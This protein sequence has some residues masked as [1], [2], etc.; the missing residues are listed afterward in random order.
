MSPRLAPSPSV[1]MGSTS[2]PYGLPLGER[3]YG[4]WGKLND[5]H[6]VLFVTGANGQYK[7]RPD[8]RECT[9]CGRADTEVDHVHA[10]EP[11]AWGQ[12]P[13]LNLVPK[14]N[15]CFYCYLAYTQKFCQKCEGG[16]KAFKTQ[17]GSCKDTNDR[18]FGLR[19]EA[20]RAVR[21]RRRRRGTL[22]GGRCRGGGGGGG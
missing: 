21:R 4:E 10:A 5:K 12:K 8:G 17:L 2:R 1:P 19:N 7:T 16:I 11:L 6:V 9:F 22:R 13:G 15:Q 14:G 18:F 20:P 3:K